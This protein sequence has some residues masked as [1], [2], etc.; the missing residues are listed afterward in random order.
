MGTDA[1][2]RVA[3]VEEVASGDQPVQSAYH[4]IIPAVCDHPGSRAGH[5]EGK[6][7]VSLQASEINDCRDS[8]TFRR[9]WVYLGH[10]SIRHTVKYIAGN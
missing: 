3:L 1:G 10:H 2:N 4:A 9:M 8:I 7:T 5:T 6:V